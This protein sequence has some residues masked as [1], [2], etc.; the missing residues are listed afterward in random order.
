MLGLKLIR[1]SKRGHWRCLVLAVIPMPFKVTSRALG[2]L[3]GFKI[4]E[5]GEIY[6]T[7]SL[8]TL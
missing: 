8:M 1:V 4:E 3:L 2:Q 7:K 5:Y 6:Q